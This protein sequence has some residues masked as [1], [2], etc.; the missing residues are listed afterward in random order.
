MPVD[1][2]SS[3]PPSARWVSIKYSMPLCRLLLVVSPPASN[4]RIAQAVCEG[5]L[6]AGDERVLVVAGAA[7][8]PAAV[9]VLNGP[10]P[11]A[12]AQNVSFAIAFARG[13]QA[14]QRQERAVDVIDAPASVPAS[15]GF[16]S[17][18]QKLDAAP[19]RR[20][21]A[22]ARREAIKRFEHAAR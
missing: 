7:F 12:G 20:M 22:A 17:A 14:A 5:V 16:L 4:P 2:S 3:Q 6:G 11:F 1:K 15:V 9:G 18:L 19:D 8:A 21:I 13:L 10:Q